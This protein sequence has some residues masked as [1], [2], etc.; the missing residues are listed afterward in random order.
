MLSFPTPRLLSE[1]G[2]TGGMSL[3]CRLFGWHDYQ[4]SV[5]M[6]DPQFNWRE[7][8][9]CGKIGEEFEHEYDAYQEY[10]A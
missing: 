5:T 7:C 2:T 3:R 8:Q 6:T 10:K 9:R 1:N 4:W